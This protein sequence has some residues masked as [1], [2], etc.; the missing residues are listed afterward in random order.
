LFAD[1]YHP[2]LLNEGIAPDGT[3]TH[4]EL[5][6]GILTKYYATVGPLTAAL[7]AVFDLVREHDIKPDDIV[8]IHADCMKRTAVFNT[9]HPANE[10]SARG[11]LPYC[12]AAAVCT[13]DPGQLLGP[14]FRPEM[15]ADKAIRAVEDKVRITENEEYERQYPEHSRARV[16]FHLR[17]GKSHTQEEDRSARGRYLRPTDEDI[18]GKFRLIAGPTLGQAKTDRVI[19]LVRKLETLPDVRELIAALRLGS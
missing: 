11:S 12:L 10:V 13:R 1:E 19:A 3:F 5:L 4:W 7:D 9:R 2:E 16:T 17:N 15:L 14:A 18:E 6:S 8:E